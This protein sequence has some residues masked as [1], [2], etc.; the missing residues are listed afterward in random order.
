MYDLI[1]K[2]CLS[3]SVIVLYPASKY[4]ALFS[5]TIN[6]KLKNIILKIVIGI[7]IDYKVSADFGIH[8]KSTAFFLHLSVLYLT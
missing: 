3:F 5:V 8:D 7:I 6:P 2:L 1:S 4:F